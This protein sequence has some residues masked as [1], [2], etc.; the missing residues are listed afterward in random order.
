MKFKI[1]KAIVIPVAIVGALASCKK[2]EENKVLPSLDGQITFQAP[3]F[4]KSKSTVS[5]KPNGVKHPDGGN[6]GYYWKISSLIEKGDTTRFENGLDKNGKESD[7]TITYTFPDTLGTFTVTCYA[8]AQGFTG[9]ST[10]SIITTIDNR[11]DGSIT[12]RGIKADDSH[13]TTDS[14][15]TYYYTTIGG[16]DWFR[17]NLCEEGG[18]P[19]RKAIILSDIFGRLYS[20]EEALNACPEGWRLPTEEDWLSLAKALG[21]PQDQA[22]FTDIPDMASKLMA[23]AKFNTTT[24]WEYWREVGDIT[25]ESKMAMIPTGFVNLGS[26]ASKPEKHDW[27][28]LT[29]P[30]AVFNGVYNYAVFWT[31]DTDNDLAYYR[32]LHVK[33]P[34]FKIATAD[35]KH[36]GASV[37]CVRDSK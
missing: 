22:K 20:H 8:Y 4:I 2:K 36:F 28:D 25:N 24:M 3:E 21:S 30:D 17:N 5:I 11:L 35:K 29:Y 23:N 34:E 12:G 13:I 37:R 27:L 33:S 16:K 32:Y 1:L 6:V 18:V 7:G 14:G 15:Q 26:K 10:Q 9:K 19:F 31:A